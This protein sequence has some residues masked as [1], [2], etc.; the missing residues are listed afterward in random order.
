MPVA[1]VSLPL[2][3][4]R[5]LT[6]VALAEELLLE[7]SEPLEP[8]HAARPRV[9]SAPAPSAMAWRLLNE[10]FMMDAMGFPSRCPHNPWGCSSQ[11]STSL[12]KPSLWVCT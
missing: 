9:D 2:V 4:V 5:A 7:L 10:E 12:A 6:P 3:C 8:P 1:T 11:T